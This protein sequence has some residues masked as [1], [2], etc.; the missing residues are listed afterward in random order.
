MRY[1]TGDVDIKTTP[2]G[3]CRG[4]RWK[5]EAMKEDSTERKRKDWQCV[6][7]TLRLAWAALGWM[8]HVGMVLVVLLVGYRRINCRGYTDL[9]VCRCTEKNSS[10]Y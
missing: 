9:E 3:V 7:W 2:D 8:G 10:L 4:W 1:E 6:T 5:Q